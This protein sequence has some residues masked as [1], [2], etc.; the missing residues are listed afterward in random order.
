MLC[1][2]VMCGCSATRHVPE[3][4]YLLDKVDIVVDDRDDVEKKE[5]YNFLR[6]VPNHKVLGF[7][8]LQLATYSLSYLIAHAGTTAC[9]AGW[10]SPR[11]LRPRAYRRLRDATPSCN[12]EPWLYARYS[13]GRYPRARKAHGGSF[14]ISMPREPHV[15]SSVGYN[16]PDTTLRRIIATH[17]RASLLR[18]RILLDRNVL[19]NERTRVTRLLRNTGYH[20]FTRDNIVFDADT[21]AGSRGVDLTFRLASGKFRALCGA[22]CDLCGGITTSTTARATLFAIP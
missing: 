4:S 17:S 3:G 13:L 10:D 9:C 19:D 22:Q 8:R 18:P 16:V 12:G 1:A 11:A 6:Q 14:I 2:L 20:D 21:V 15:V 5:L 7:A